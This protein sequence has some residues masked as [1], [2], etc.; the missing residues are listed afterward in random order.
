MTDKPAVTETRTPEAM[1]NGDLSH[2]ARGG[3]ELVQTPSQTPLNATGR[4]TG[5]FG[6]KTAG[7]SRGTG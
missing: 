4:D 3:A 1:Q 7:M 2:R 6:H 5:V